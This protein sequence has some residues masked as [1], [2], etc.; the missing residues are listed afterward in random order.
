MNEWKRLNIEGDEWIT[1][2]FIDFGIW[3]YIY[4]YIYTR[5]VL[6]YIPHEFP[7]RRYIELLY[8][9]RDFE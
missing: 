1:I 9:S 4:C 3:R 6:F 8:H 5:E 2:K 7:N